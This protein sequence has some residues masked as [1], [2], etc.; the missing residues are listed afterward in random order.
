MPHFPGLR[1]V[2]TRIRTVL[3]LWLVVSVAAH[4]S[5][6]TSPARRALARAGLLAGLAGAALGAGGAVTAS[7]A[8]PGGPAPA[9]EAQEM[10]GAKEVK[11]G[12]LGSAQ[13][14]GAAADGG[15]GA[16]KELQLNPLANTGV[17]PLDNGIGAQ[18]ADFK[19]V[20]T[21][22]VTESLARGASL[23][24]LPVVGSV[25]EPLPG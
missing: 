20:N 15:L 5:R 17:D 10:P 8:E 1:Y 14:L 23:D 11:E 21:R 3:T 25:T 19:P 2:C 7:A 9:P 22:L 24:E 4:A 18:V 12:I 13:G 16:V 6:P